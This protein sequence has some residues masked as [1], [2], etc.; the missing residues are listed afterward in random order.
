MSKTT[1]MQMSEEAVKEKQVLTIKETVMRS[2]EKGMPISEYTLR[3]AVRSGAIP[4][5]VIG[6]TY[7]IAWRNVE[8]WL[9]CDDGQDNPPLET[10]N[11]GS[12]QIR[13]IEVV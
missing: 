2:R 1:W 4:C 13:K 11:T 7:L 9:L 8:R 5:R 10:H 3:R 6:K 12:G